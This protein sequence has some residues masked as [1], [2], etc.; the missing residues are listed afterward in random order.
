M[1]FP[2]YVRVQSG[3]LEKGSIKRSAGNGKKSLGQER[4][5]C[6]AEIKKDAA[7]FAASFEIAKWKQFQ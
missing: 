6:P 7:D 2:G 4:E 1:D 5:F 3:K